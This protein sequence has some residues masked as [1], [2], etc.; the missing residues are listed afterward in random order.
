[1]FA[2]YLKCRIFFLHLR[3]TSKYQENLCT[4][5]TNSVR[6]NNGKKCQ[7]RPSS[8]IANAL[9][10]RVVCH[11][12][13]PSGCVVCYDISND[14]IIR[15]DIYRLVCNTMKGWKS[16]CKHLFFR[17]GLSEESIFDD[18]L[19]KLYQKPENFLVLHKDG[20]ADEEM[21]YKRIAFS[22][23]N[24]LRDGYRKATCPVTCPAN[25]EADERERIEDSKSR[26]QRF[27]EIDLNQ[28]FPEKNRQVYSEDDIKAF[29]KFVSDVLDSNPELK[30]IFSM[31]TYQQMEPK[32]IGK[33]IGKT[34]AQI[35]K[36]YFNAKR[37]LEKYAECHPE[38]VKQYF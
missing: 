30:K 1:M 25:D 35:N 6:Q 11:A 17:I 27:T 2:F 26:V 18:I 8:I 10:E 19:L 20:T 16:N 31:R 15:E 28:E 33:L 12:I 22:I 29:R 24:L 21:T 38:I 3:K 14:A 5:S 9:F 4:M 32:E 37:R 23:Q 7:S 13:L 36:K 34:D